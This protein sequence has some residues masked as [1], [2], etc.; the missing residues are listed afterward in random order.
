[1][2]PTSALGLHLLDCEF[3]PCLQYWL[4]LSIFTEGGR[5][6]VC[7]VLADPFGDHHVGCGGNGDGIHRHNSIRD[8]IF[9]AAQTAALAPRRELP[10][11]IP[12]SQAR[13][14]DIFLPSWD[15]GRPTALDV[16]VISTLQQLT[17]QG[18]AITPGHALAVGENRKMTMHASHC[19]A[20]GVSFVP[21][22]IESLWGWSDLAVK[23]ISSIGRLLGQR[24][25]ILPSNSV[26]FHSGGGMPLYGYTDTQL[27][28]H[29]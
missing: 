25:G 16:T 17:L 14:A 6:P 19:Q 9:L 28:P 29:T 12:G 18:A 3:R 1:M 21:L 20:V 5:C 8:A 15:R 24:L 4:G 26:Q 22:V 7:Q 2:V 11:L 27:F 23:T 10:S 13:P